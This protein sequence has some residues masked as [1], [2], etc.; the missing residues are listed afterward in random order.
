MDVF[1]IL[2]LSRSVRLRH[3]WFS[4]ENTERETTSLQETKADQ[5]LNIL[6]IAECW[7]EIGYTSK[8]SIINE[9][10]STQFPVDTFFQMVLFG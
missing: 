9:S 4:D 3:K 8:G 5:I 2:Q 1:W 6:N 10:W 7:C